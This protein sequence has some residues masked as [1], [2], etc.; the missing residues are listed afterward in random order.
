MNETR[1]R[2]LMGMALRAGQ[3]V[4]GEEA[5]RKALRSGEC[6]AL[7]LD[8]EI[9]EGSERKYRELCRRAGTPLCKLPAGLMEEATGRPGM[10]MAL[11]KGSFAQRAAEGLEKEAP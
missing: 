8:G 2:G 3:A 1:M 7:L 10:A 9:S 4:F 5:C 6:G 11:K